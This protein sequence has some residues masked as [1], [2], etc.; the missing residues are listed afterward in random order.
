MRFKTLGITMVRNE[1]DILETFIRHNL[2]FL[3]GIAVI[4]NLSVDRTGEILRAMTREGLP[5]F[6]IDDPVPGYFQSEKLSNLLARVCN[7]FFPDF[8]VPLD[9]DELIQAASRESFLSAISACPAPSVSYVPWV[10]YIP[11]PSAPGSE[12]APQD[13]QFRR[14]SEDPAYFKAIIGTTG[15]PFSDIT[16]LQGAHSIASKSVRFNSTVLSD[17]RLAHF[18]VRGVSQMKCKIIL[19]WLAYL[20]RDPNA[21][22]RDSGYQWLNIY[23]KIMDGGGEIDYPT[24]TSLAINYAQNPKTGEWT[25]HVVA[26]APSVMDFRERFSHERNKNVLT[27][28]IRSWEAQLTSRQSLISTADLRHVATPQLPDKTSTEGVFPGDWHIKNLFVDVQPFRHLFDR[29]GPESVLDVGCGAGQYLHLLKKLGTKQVL[30]IDGFHPDY[31]F[32]NDDEY[33]IHDLTTPFRTGQRFDLVM[34]LEV[35]EHMPAGSEMAL[36]SCLEEHAKK[37]ILFSAAEPGQPGEG[38][39][40]CKP[41]AFWADIFGSR[42]WTPLV[43]ESLSFRAIASLSWLRRNPVLLT[44]GDADNSTGKLAW[45]VLLGIAQKRFRWYSQ[46]PAIINEPL[47]CGIPP[48]YAR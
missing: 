40:N 16:V 28:V 15:E 8:V 1:D 36:I 43:F 32:L 11:H 21:A 9:A 12:L 20:A 30:G 2:Q 47:R 10:T 35:A 7:A 24:L 3:D 6:V 41:L 42:G 25:D 5:L 22:A 37:Y 17:V 18:P 14:K 48:A 39:I 45:D 26:D 13:F 44:K 23:N 38:H 29:I 27:T 31:S 19:G 4:N 33:L 46:Q 34:C